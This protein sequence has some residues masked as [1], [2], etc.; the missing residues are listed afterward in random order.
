MDELM[1][2]DARIFVKVS[3]RRFERD[4]AVPNEGTFLRGRGMGDEREREC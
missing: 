1:V 4:T 3:G 2:I